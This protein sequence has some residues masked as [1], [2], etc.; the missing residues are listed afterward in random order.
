MPLTRNNH[1]VPEW[2][3]QLFHEPGNGTLAYLDLKPPQHVLGIGHGRVIGFLVRR[4]RRGGHDLLGRRRRCQ[5]Q[6]AQRRRAP[7]HRLCRVAMEPGRDSKAS[8]ALSSRT[9][10][11]PSKR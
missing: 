3:Q 8:V 7:H 1:Y 2:Y 9:R 4:M 5:Q 11:L 6:G 10:L